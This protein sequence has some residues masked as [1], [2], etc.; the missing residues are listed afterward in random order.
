V[1]PLPLTAHAEIV[2]AERG[3]SSASIEQ[4]A[5]R[6]D[7]R[8]ADATTAGAERR[9]FAPPEAGGRV[10][11]VVCVETDSDIRVITVFFDRNAKRPA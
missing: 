11:R 9:F 8:E 7:W 5:H 3:I 1:K 4:A 6:P 10:L 2:A